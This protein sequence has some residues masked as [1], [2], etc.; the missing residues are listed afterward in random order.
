MPLARPDDLGSVYAAAMEKQE[1]VTA[2]F[3]CKLRVGGVQV[4]CSLRQ[5]QLISAFL[6][7]GAKM[8]NGRPTK[9]IRSVLD[10]A[11]S[12]RRSLTVHA[13]TNSGGGNGNAGAP[14]WLDQPP[15]ES[16]FLLDNNES[17]PALL[18][19]SARLDSSSLR[20]ELKLP[21]MVAS[22]LR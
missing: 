6:A 19:E 18:G 14:S 10:Q 4:V 22:E 21:N 15:D 20:L 1:A 9:T 5:H 11:K 7:S 3:D 2:R 13:P 17:S 12:I 8:R 16:S